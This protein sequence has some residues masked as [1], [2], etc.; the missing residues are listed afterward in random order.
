L[1]KSFR[2]TIHQKS[3][4]SSL[5][6]SLHKKIVTKAS[7]PSE[8][9]LEILRSRTPARTIALIPN[10]VHQALSHGWIESKNLVEWLSID[11]GRLAERIASEHE[12]DW[13]INAYKAA[14]QREKKAS[15]LKQ[16]KI[17]GNLLASHVTLG[18]S[19]Y[20]ILLT[21]S[22]DVVREWTAFIVANQNSVAFKRKLAWIKSQADDLH[23]GVREVAWIAMRDQVIEQ[24][25]LA[26]DCLIP[27][28]G[29]RSERLRRYASEI[30]RPCGVWAAHIPTLK[31]SPEMAL[32]ILEPLRDDDSKYVRNS[33]ANW[34][35]D[36]SKSQPDWVQVVVKRWLHESP[37]KNTV[38]IAKRALRSLRVD[39]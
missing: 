11:R 33:V 21:H 20:Q 7:K 1:R 4:L 34:L 15:A 29:S 27:W 37:T 38:A 12:I 10:D 35:N 14:T 26:I 25:E 13:D 9:S 32:E 30:T 23:P 6:S 8:K 16:S 22:S 5:S 36:A 19:H 3:F 17:V 18:G 31:K 24:L 28:T 2:L 39:P